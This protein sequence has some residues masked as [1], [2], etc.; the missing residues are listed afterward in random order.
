MIITPIRTGKVTF[1]TQTME[2]F[3]DAHLPPLREGSIIVITSKVL[4]ITE[5]AIK[6]VEEISK[7]ELAEREADYIL[8]MPKKRSHGLSITVKNGMLIA[9]AG[10]DLSNG[11]GYYVFWP[12]DPQKSANL[13]RAHLKKRFRLKD[14]GVIITDT[15]NQVLRRGTIG[16]ALAHS[17]FR[18]LKYYKGLPDVFGRILASTN[19]KSILEGLAVSAV[20]TMGEA[21]EQT[22]IALIEDIPFVEFQKRNPTKKEIE[23][24]SMDME[25]D[26]FSQILMSAKWRKG[27]GGIS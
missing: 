15:R 5:G 3:L 11:N 2:E 16:T 14:V 10:V 18:A 7:T 24:L 9:N 1:G 22:P 20:L 27:G 23:D 8:D 19:A 4:A 12:R 21:A 6:P 13:A 25:K 26:L 17:G